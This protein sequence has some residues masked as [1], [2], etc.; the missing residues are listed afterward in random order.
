MLEGKRAIVTGAS[1]GI[2]RAI[3]LRLAREG[4][5]VYLAAD[6]TG[7]ELRGAAAECG[8]AGAKAAW[9]V[10]DLARKEGP[11]AVVAGAQEA[12]GGVDILVNNA[13][14]RAPHRFGEFTPEDFDRLVAVNLRAPFL[15]SQAVLPAMRAAGGGRI[16]HIASQ[17]GQVAAPRSALYS[18]TKA[19]LIQLAR[20]MALELAPEGITVNCVSPGPTGTEYYLDRMSRNPGERAQR[21]SYIPAGRF[22]EPGEIAGAVAFL[23]SGEAAF[24]QGHNFVVDGG[25][26]VH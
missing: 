17:L 14:I 20:S 5:A 9:G 24:V 10:F 21:L 13:G 3:A 15:A 7:D 12:L 16:I 26:L 1:R 11:G 19:A 25:Y 22:A 4:A 6:G 8:R 23:A 18:L 2:G